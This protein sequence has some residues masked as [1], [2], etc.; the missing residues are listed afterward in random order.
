MKTGIMGGT[1]DPVHLGHIEMA[2]FCKK[3]FSLDKIMFLPLGDAPH[4][5]N[6]TDKNIRLEMLFS[7]LDGKKDFFVSTLE[8]D[9]VGKTYTYDTLKILTEEK[10]A[11]YSYIIGADTAEVLLTWFRAQDVFKM[12]DFIVVG[13]HDCVLGS[14]ALQAE[15]AGAT[16]RFANHTGLDISS[17]EIRQKVANGENIEKLVGKKVFEVIKKYGLYTDRTV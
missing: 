4:K 11:E 3:E 7:A 1:F 9:R 12:T 5:K 16:F 2:E 6:V 15:K 13:R 17:T 10:N 14:G 8:T